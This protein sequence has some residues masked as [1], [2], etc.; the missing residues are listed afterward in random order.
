MIKGL[1]KALKKDEDFYYGWQSNIAMS[2]WDEMNDNKIILS[3]SEGVL[4]K[5]QEHIFIN[6]CA[7]RFLDL[8]IGQKSDDGMKYSSIFKEKIN[9]N[10]EGEVFKE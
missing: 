3:T 1:I 10:N 8:L 9:C 7:K 5:E 4:T 6:D 2:I